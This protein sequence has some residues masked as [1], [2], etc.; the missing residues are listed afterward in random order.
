MP[1]SQSTTSFSKL[2]S[3][4]SFWKSIKRVLPQV[5]I[6]AGVIT[7]IIGSYFRFFDNYEFETYDWRCR[8]KPA[9]PISDKIVIVHIGDY[10]LQNIGE[11]PFSRDLHADLIEFMQLSNARMLGF[12]VLFVDHT[13]NDERMRQAALDYGQVY[14]ANAFSTPYSDRG[15]YKAISLT[16]SPLR[17][18]LEVA[19]GVGYVNMLTD[20]D[21][22][23]RR[24]APM[25]EVEGHAFWNWSVLMA[26]DYLGIS[27]DAIHYD[28]QG[29]LRLGDYTTLPLDS[30]GSFLVHY[31]GMWGKVFRHYSYWDLIHS[32]HQIKQGE[33]PF[34]DPKELEGTVAF[35]GLVATG[36]HDIYPV[37]IQ[38][39]YP[40]IGMH[41]S[42]FN[43][44]LQ[45]SY[46]I[47][48]ARWINLLV[49]I[50]LTLAAFY[51][52]RIPKLPLSILAALGSILAFLSIAILCFTL[53]RFWID[54]FYPGMA[55]GALYLTGVLRRTM[56]EKRKRELMEAELTIASKIQ[57]SFL[58]STLPKAPSLDLAAYMH[59]AKH[60]GGDMY[61]L[62]E[63][64]SDHIGVLLGDVSGKGT[65]AALFMAK[66]MAEFK[67]HARGL[68]DP[69]KVL[70]NLNE[71]LSAEDCGG[72]FVTINYA[73]FNHK[74]HK[75]ILSNAGHMPVLRINQAG[76]V[77][78]LTPEGGMPVALMPGIEF[79]NLEVDLKPGDMFILYS[80]GIS[81]AR[82]DHKVDYEM[83]R[84]EAVLKPIR[85]KPADEI[86]KG[87][88]E[89]IKRFVGGAP[90]HD[91]MTI[92]V[93]KALQ[94]T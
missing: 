91:D 42:V 44:I 92:L 68:I 65:P 16:T 69:A 75:M 3:A 6:I 74:E 70:T 61:T 41:A 33:K 57:R 24:I 7:L 85:Q 35:V 83:E 93:V 43:S 53:A 76:E 56:G 38:A 5:A 72:L 49:L 4:K 47:R 59:A 19:R 50:V 23:R 39:L 71:S 40:Q 46:I 45:Q 15:R 48:A 73:I 84:L 25:L 12:D 80:D 27:H 90:Q 28:K 11:W 63:I 1:Q 60:V 64:D 9:P 87:V 13:A 52:A 2:F 36:S 18:F 29:N 32:L 67:F 86:Q 26:A 21:G 79:L 54:M 81:E 51:L 34:I 88:L 55:F 17:A 82:N 22:K 89:D 37:P 30:D 66:T 10:A 77:K 14:L 58:P 20:S 31:P 94:K 62:F 8:V 78:H